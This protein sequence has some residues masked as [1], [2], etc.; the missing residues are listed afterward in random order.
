VLIEDLVVMVAHM[1]VEVVDEEVSYVEM[2]QG[3]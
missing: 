2:S 1:D 3:C